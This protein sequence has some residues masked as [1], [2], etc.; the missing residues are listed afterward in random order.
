MIG[1]EHLLVRVRTA[2]Y[3][4]PG[5]FP[6]LVTHVGT[7]GNQACNDMLICWIQSAEPKVMSK[8]VSAVKAAM[9]VMGCTSGSHI[10]KDNSAGILYDGH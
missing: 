3:A 1:N 2:S 8:L 9:A 10:N 5:G 7:C 6:I 4:V